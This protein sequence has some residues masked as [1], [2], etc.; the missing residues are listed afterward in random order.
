MKAVIYYTY[1]DIR[2]EEQPIP[3]ITDH[4]LLVHHD[5]GV[6]GQ[7]HYYQHQNYSMYASFK[8]SNIDPCG[9]AEYMRVSAE[10]IQHT[11]LPLPEM[12]SAKVYFQIAGETHG[13]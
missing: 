4:E 10:H 2:T 6:C 8:A 7:C 1:N 13:K 5:C 12:I 3:V 9:C 11:T